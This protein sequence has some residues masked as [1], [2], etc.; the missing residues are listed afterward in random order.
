MPR[1]TLPRAPK[2]IAQPR[3]MFPRRHRGLYILII[4]AVCVLAANAVI[5]ERG[6][7]ESRKAERRH[8]NLLDSIESL[9]R[10]NRSLHNH[11]KRL[12]ED[13]TII[14]SIARQELGLIRP[15]EIVFIVKDRLPATGKTP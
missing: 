8:D 6:L 4:L 13:P 3:A 15:G 7:L 12:R 11:A 1:I 10:E 2:G 9:Q 14:E 5:G